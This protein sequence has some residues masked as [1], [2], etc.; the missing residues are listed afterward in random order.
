MVE[1]IDMF[2]ESS[3]NG[4]N[5]RS[6]YDADDIQCSKASLRCANGQACT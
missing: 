1:Q 4:G 6:G 5:N 2:A 3:K